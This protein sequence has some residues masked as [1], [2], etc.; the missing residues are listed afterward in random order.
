MFFNSSSD[1]DPYGDLRRREEYERQQNAN[2]ARG[3]GGF[4]YKYIG[5]WFVWL[6]TGA[7][8][9]TILQKVFELSFGMSFFIGV[10]LSVIIFKVPYVKE[11]PYKSFIVICFVF[12][13]FIVAFP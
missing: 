2:I 7:F 6:F 5:Y 10:T 3:V 9:G 4:F 13:L 12:G 8:S 1:N 11:N